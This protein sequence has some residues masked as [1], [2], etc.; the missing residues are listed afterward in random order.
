MS[1][2][3][4]LKTKGAKGNNIEEAV[5]TLPIG[6]GGASTNHFE[7]VFSTADWSAWSADKTYTE[8]SD[9][10]TSGKIVDAYFYQSG[11]VK[12]PIIIQGV[13]A[14]TVTFAQFQPF[15]S[16][17]YMYIYEWTYSNNGNLV[18]SYNRYTL[19]QFNG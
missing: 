11:G 14:D 2:L 7:I 9:A 18:A 6:G 15:T 8:L 5:K 1:I 4:A 10:I 17:G 12:T 3:S 19:T 13:G 16:E